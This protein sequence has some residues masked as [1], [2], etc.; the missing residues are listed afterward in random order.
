M[1][2]N[3]IWSCNKCGAYETKQNAKN[4]ICYSNLKQEIKE[5][6]KQEIKEDKKRGKK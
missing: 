3:N 1:D 4:H 6:I 5:E 2:L